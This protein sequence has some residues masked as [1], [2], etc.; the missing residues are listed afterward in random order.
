MEALRPV[1][2]RPNPTVHIEI[3]YNDSK[4]IHDSTMIL[5]SSVADNSD[6]RERLISGQFT[7][8]TIRFT[9]DDAYLFSVP[10]MDN[11]NVEYS[12]EIKIYEGE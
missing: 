1:I 5:E 6:I 2:G 9:I 3:P 10:F 8:M 7:R 11:W 4:I 12:D